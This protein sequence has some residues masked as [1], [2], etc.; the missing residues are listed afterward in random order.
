MKFSDENE[1]SKPI[2]QPIYL[3]FDILNQFVLYPLTQMADP[4]G[5]PC[6]QLLSLKKLSSYGE[7]RPCHMEH[8]HK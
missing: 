8:A 3:D 4:Y 7:G 6:D 2:I 1:I 5:L